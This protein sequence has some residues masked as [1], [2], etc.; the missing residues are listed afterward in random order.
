MVNG[1]NPFSSWRKMDVSRMIRLVL[2]WST[3]MLGPAAGMAQAA[4]PPA[5]WELQRVGEPTQDHPDTL[6]APAIS[7][8]GRR[9]VSVNG[10]SLRLWD[11]M[12]GEPV[13]KPMI[14]RA[15]IR[16]IVW[17]PDG[18]FIASGDYEGLLALWDAERRELL[19]KAPTGHQHVYAIAFS[20][21]G[22]QI[23][24]GGKKDGTL[25]L[26]ER[27]SG[28]EFGQPFTGH[29]REITALTFAD[30][31]KTLISTGMDGTLRVWNVDTRTAVRTIQ[32]GF[33]R[34]PWHLARHP[35]QPVVA[36]SNHESIAFWNYQTGAPAG[37]T[38]KGYGAAHGMSGLAFTEDG[39]RLMAADSAGGMVL[40][41]WQKG[42][43][44]TRG[45]AEH[46]SEIVWETAFSRNG[47]LVATA[48]KDGVLGIWRA[49]VVDS[50]P[51]F[52]VSAVRK[53]PHPHGGAVTFYSHDGRYMAHF[54]RQVTVVDRNTNAVVFDD[55]NGGHGYIAAFS[56]DNQWFAFVGAG[57]QVIAIRLPSR[58]RVPA[59]HGGVVRHRALAFSPDG[60]R[61]AIGVQES[62]N[63]NVSDSVILVETRTGKVSGRYTFE[64]I[65]YH[66]KI[67]SGLAFS[68]D[69]RTLLAATQDG[70]VAR[71]NASTMQPTGKLWAGLGRMVV[72]SPDGRRVA[73]VR[74]AGYGNVHAVIVDAASGEQLTNPVSSGE[75]LSSLAFTP[76]G[77]FLLAAS[78][79]RI[80]TLWDAVTGE[81]LGRHQLEYVWAMRNIRITPDAR[82][83]Y[84]TSGEGKDYSPFQMM[85]WEIAIDPS[86]LKLTPAV[87]VVRTRPVVLTSDIVARMPSFTPTTAAFVPGG[88]QLAV[89]TLGM[90]RFM[91]GSEVRGTGEGLRVSGDSPRPDPAT[92]HYVAVSRDG[93]RASAAPDGTEMRVYD[94]ATGKR[95]S[96]VA[97][98][99]YGKNNYV[100]RGHGPHSFLAD[101]RLALTWE[102]GA[103]IIDPERGLTLSRRQFPLDSYPTAIA[104]GNKS[105]AIAVGTDKGSV[106]LI[107]ADDGSP[108]AGIERAHRGQITEIV[109]SPNDRLVVTGDVFGSVRLFDAHSG[110]AIAGPWR[111]HARAVT[112]MAFSSDGEF[113]AS[114]SSDGTLRVWSVR[115]GEPVTHALVGHTEPVLAMMYEKAGQ[116][117]TYSRDGTLRRWRIPLDACPAIMATEATVIA[118]I[119]NLRGQPTSTGEVLATLAF[120]TRVRVLERTQSCT[121]VADRTGRWVRVHPVDDAT[122]REGWIFDPFVMYAPKNREHAKSGAGAR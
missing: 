95:V 116:W 81:R 6:R 16:T 17:S 102:H 60:S 83:V 75:G 35:R 84:A 10:A 48:G 93:R 111:A 51:G 4:K 118:D 32:T 94:V 1:R 122:M 59:G 31:G 88:S 11:A 76:D 50:I 7:P 98:S 109:F 119:V 21:D 38:L 79:N 96:I 37:A 30:N 14:N 44:V 58:Q 28:R 80:V 103:R 87:P 66:S 72:F 29:T 62:V 70:D 18:R 64:A 22:A 100:S 71:L 36:V 19:W 85:E 39:Q 47:E 92:I 57:Q 112:A 86:R 113:L 65:P 13:G 26:W 77:R 42:E 46:R 3:L 99:G 27:A 52:S 54:G 121:T 73:A 105:S 41:D 120:G 110:R 25:R 101:G 8:D 89:G 91:Q 45:V 20:P 108:P 78:G 97:N 82:R 117:L 69:G 68:P 9:V 23:A 24:T 115:T 114:G 107:Q 63:S 5:V 104:A 34:G 15:G 55:V 33:D 12:T 106:W 74:H 2:C 49:S 67:V 40:I 90:L 53:R 56:P 43:I 61:L